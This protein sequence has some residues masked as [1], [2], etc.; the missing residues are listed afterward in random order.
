MLLTFQKYFAAQY[1]AHHWISRQP[2]AYLDPKTGR[3]A[4]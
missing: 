3:T 1:F 4:T 2:L